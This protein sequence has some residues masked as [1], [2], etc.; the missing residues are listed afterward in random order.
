MCCIDGE[1]EFNFDN[2]RVTLTPGKLLYLPKGID[3][4]I[5]T[6]TVKSR[7]T[8]YNIYFD[9]ACAM[10]RRSVLVSPKANNFPS[11]YEKVYRI[12]AG[13]KQGYYYEAMA[14]AYKI[15]RLVYSTQLNYSPSKSTAHLAAADNYI[16][17][18]YCDAKFDYAALK[19][20]C[21]LS[22]SYFKKLFIEKYGM[23]PV[24]YITSLKVKRA[25]ELLLTNM[26][27]VS[28]VAEMCGFE[29]VYYFS[30]VFKSNLGVSPR[31]YSALVPYFE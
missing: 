21:G 25:C 22:Y 4:D 7:L 16:S 15:F 24:K 17:E 31:N 27:T 6:I 23:P 3:N 11:L 5:Y 10:P 19:S 8:N 18:H 1:G 9:T 12:W 14:E 30:N 2:R 29:S 26:F 13:K 20:A 28:E